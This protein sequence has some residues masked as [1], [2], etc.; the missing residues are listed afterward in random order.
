M[1]K[2]VSCSASREYTHGEYAKALYRVAGPTYKTCR[3]FHLNKYGSQIERQAL[4]G[5]KGARIE[6]KPEIPA[7][8]TLTHDVTGSK[9]A[10]EPIDSQG[11]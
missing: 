1:I 6:A 9:I 7:G 10:R 8:C 11:L 3:E 5:L 4:A 2:T